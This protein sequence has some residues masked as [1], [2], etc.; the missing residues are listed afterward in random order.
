M[1]TGVLANLISV[2]KEY[3]TAIELVLGAA[4]QNIVTEK[5]EDAKKLI[6]HLRKNNLGRASFLPISSVKGKKIDKIIKKDLN[7]VI[8]IASD[9]I[10]VNNKYEEI[11]LNLLGRTVIVDNMDTGISLSK[12]NN[13][14]FR[15]VTLKGDIINPSGLM[16]GGSVS[17]KSSS[18]IGR[19]AQ[20]DDLKEDL[21][22]IEKS[23]EKISKEKED[24]EKSIEGVLEEVASLE[25]SMQDT[26]I[27]YATEK[28]KVVS[29]SE[30]ITK[31][32]SKLQKLKDEL[33]EIDNTKKGNLEN[34]KELEAEIATL[35]QEIEELNAVINEYAEKNKDNQKYIDDLNFDITNLKISVSSFDESNTSIDEMVA[36][37][38]QDIENSKLSIENK[39]E[40]KEKMLEDN[41]L[42]EE[43]ITNLNTQI[44][45]IKKAVSTSSEK[46]EELKNK[47]IEK[48]IELKELEE[49]INNQFKIIEALKE[50]ISKLEVKKSKIELE[51]EQVVNK[52]WEE[53][54]VT[55]NNIGEYKKPENVAATNKRVKTLRE[56]IKNLGSVNV[57]A[58]AE[59]SETKKR[60]DFM[61]EQRLDL[62]D[63]SSKLKKVIQDMTKIMKDQFTK[64]FKIINKNFGQVFSELFGGGE[65]TLKLTDE[66]NVLECGID[67]EVQ[68]PGKR[69]QSMSLLSRWRKSLYS[70]SITICNI[71]N[72]PSTVLCT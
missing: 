66:E 22:N 1:Y 46:V 17:Q 6:E 43:E 50:Q 68:P 32:E 42:L 16:T 2:P 18:I 63:A 36:R 65:A 37:I 40:L 51:L 49:N 14:S 69:L 58:I 28:Q 48:N 60:Y 44:E 41:K 61:C 8:G 21:K 35:E 38:D 12:S 53:Y 64:Q 20:I 70:N 62:E 57:D 5:E 27:V 4:L 55:P 47:R 13:Y 59:Y 31:L 3:E 34:T 19:Q 54:E 24:Y 26:E 29:I 71:K 15:I 45:E 52:M 9:L 33:V 30:N 10:S 72:K 39:K 56:E 23:I 67:I 7:G 25:Q 11:I